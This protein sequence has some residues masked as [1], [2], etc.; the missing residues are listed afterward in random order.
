MSS[1]SCQGIRELI[2]VFDVLGMFLVEGICQ[3]I[4]KLEFRTELEKWHVEIA[5]YAQFEK[6]FRFLELDVV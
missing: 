3:S 1:F 6:Y 5:A 4:H 2:L